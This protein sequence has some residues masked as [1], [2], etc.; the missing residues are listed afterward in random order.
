MKPLPLS[1]AILLLAL[2][3]RRP[4][5]VSGFP[6][7]DRVIGTSDFTS[8]GSTTASATSL[9]SPSG[10]AIDPTSG[11]LF[12]ASDT[13]HRILRYPDV[14]SLEN[15]AAAEAV[16]GQ[17]SYTT[18]APGATASTLHSPRDSTSMPPGGSG[19]GRFRQPP[20]PHV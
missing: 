17:T 12:V 20:R 15:G 10:L 16:I 1:L 14:A 19:W 11:K 13:Q 18:T 7:A 3:S 5:P 2:S 4:G 8:Q 9:R 6:A